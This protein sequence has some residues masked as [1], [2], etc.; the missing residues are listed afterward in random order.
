MRN[1]IALRVLLLLF[2][3]LLGAQHVP[4]FDSSLKELC[5][6]YYA[7]PP[8]LLFVL[9]PHCWKAELY[10]Y[11]DCDCGKGFQRLSNGMC[12]RGQCSPGYSPTDEGE[13]V[14]CPDKSSRWCPAMKTC[15]CQKNFQL[16]E[17]NRCVECSENKISNGYNACRCPSYYTYSSDGTCERC[18]E[19]EVRNPL[20]RRCECRTYYAH[21]QTGHCILCSFEHMEVHFSSDNDKICVCS[22]GFRMNTEGFCVA[23]PRR[24]GFKFVAVGFAIVS[25]L[26]LI[27][28]YAVRQ[29][30]NN[31]YQ[32]TS[33]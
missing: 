4:D 8:S 13:C 29:Y 5:N 32:H 30:M 9:D 3:T 12:Q 20:T 16:D 24:Y 25:T 27:C 2:P 31:G 11:R 17:N 1:V 14:H 6:G 26:G 15:I 10:D 33:A 28:G 19:N 21:N 18:D 22:E 7:E 23:R